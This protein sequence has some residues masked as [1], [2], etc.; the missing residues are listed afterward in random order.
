MTKNSIQFN[1]IH[2]FVT[3]DLESRAPGPRAV[4]IALSRRKCFGKND[5][6]GGE[7]INNFISLAHEILR[8]QGLV[9]K[10]GWTKNKYYLGHLGGIIDFEIWS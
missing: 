7:E 3:L 2:K 8:L 6:G 9:I 10:E 4:E 1:S 5:C